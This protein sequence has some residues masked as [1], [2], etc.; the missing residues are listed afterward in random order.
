M[1]MPTP[2]IPL[3]PCPRCGSTHQEMRRGEEFIRCR[4]CGHSIPLGITVLG[5]LIP[6]TERLPPLGYIV[7]T[8]QTGPS[9]PGLWVLDNY[10]DGACGNGSEK[11]WKKAEA[12]GLTVTHWCE[13]PESPRRT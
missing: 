13:L 8:W 2:T 1:T 7:L 6:V 3:Q 4:A 12:G 10:G 5:P 9:T 11:R